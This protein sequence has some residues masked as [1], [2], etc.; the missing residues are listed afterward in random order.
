MSEEEKEETYPFSP[1]FDHSKCYFWCGNPYCDS[2][3]LVDDEE[4]EDFDD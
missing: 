3:P 4:E 1:K 2:K